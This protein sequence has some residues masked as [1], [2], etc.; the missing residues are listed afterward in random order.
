MVRLRP[1]NWNM[2]LPDYRLGWAENNREACL[3]NVGPLTSLARALGNAPAQEVHDFAQRVYGVQFYCPEHGKYEVGPDGKSVSCSIHGTVLAPK[4]PPAQ[5]ES[6]AP[7]K[8][9]RDFKDLA[10]SLT[11]LEDGLHAVMQIE[12]K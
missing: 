2:V 6:S 9:L 4:Q 12:R 1:E 10:V 8:L 5:T 3:N 11:F 7:N